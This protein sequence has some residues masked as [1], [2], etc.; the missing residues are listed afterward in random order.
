MV[1]YIVVTQIVGQ[2]VLSTEQ[3]DFAFT[4]H[5]ATFNAKGIPAS[6]IETVDE[7]GVCQHAF[8]NGEEQRV[9]LTIIKGVAQ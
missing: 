3:F 4:N 8:L 1:N 7:T 5:V 2:S 6:I 9:V